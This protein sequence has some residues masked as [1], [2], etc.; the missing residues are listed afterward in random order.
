MFTIYGFGRNTNNEL[1]LNSDTKRPQKITRLSNEQ[2]TQIAAP[3]QMTFFLTNTNKVIEFGKNAGRGQITHQIQGEKIVSI[4]AGTYHCIM[5]CE[6]GNAYGI[7]ENKNGQLG[8]GNTITQGRPTLIRFFQNNNLRITQIE[9]NYYNTYFICENGDLYGCGMSERIRRTNTSTNTIIPVRI[10]QNV[11]RVFSGPEAGGYF[12][13]TRDH[14]LYGGGKNFSG[15][16]G[17][18]TSN[19][20]PHDPTELRS[21]ANREI[22]DIAFGFTSSVLIDG[23]GKAFSCGSSANNGLGGSSNQLTFRAIPS[24]STLRFNKI[25]VGQDHTI[26]TTELGQIYIWGGSNSYGQL[27]SG[28]TT[29]SASPREL[30]IQELRGCSSLQLTCGLYNT[31]IYTTPVDSLKDDFQLLFD[32]HESTDLE[33]NGIPVHSILLQA[34]TSISP[35]TVKSTLE[36][37]F[38]EEETVVFLKWAYYELVSDIET[39]KRITGKF[40]IQFP[41][42][43]KLKEDLHR[44]YRDEQSKDFTIILE[45]NQQIK[46]HKTILQARSELFRGMFNNVQDN[47]NTVND[48]SG[49]SAGAMYKFIK[50]LYTDVLELST[51]DSPQTVFEELWDVV[52]YYQLNTNSSMRNELYE[53]QRMN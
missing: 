22:T 33:V 43:R 39:L 14:R 10:F 45:N 41:E 25:A 48:F 29:V 20:G 30:V 12:F 51:N 7:R 44:L 40:D 37:N 9:T 36:E 26:L 6:S 23:E 24:I 4:S 3:Y 50:F 53:L 52:D 32:R 2:V 47:S 17:I 28:N 38:T 13:T 34:R 31:I 27:G 19:V 1:G 11:E 16:L 18:G 5:L 35:F 49:R 8:L 42:Q 21:W 15:S 46:V